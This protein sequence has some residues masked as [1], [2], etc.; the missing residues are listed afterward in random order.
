MVK[1]VNYVLL[2]VLMMILSLSSVCAADGDINDNLTST[3]DIN[4]LIT[5]SSIDL[6]EIEDVDILQHE[7]NDN[8]VIYDN[9]QV[10]ISE[11]NSNNVSFTDSI[12]DDANDEQVIC[13]VDSVYNNYTVICNSSY[14]DPQDV[15]SSIF[16]NDVSNN[17]LTYDVSD[18]TSDVVDDTVV[19][20]D[21]SNMT[22]VNDNVIVVD[23]SDVTIVDDDNNMCSIH[24][25][26]N[27]GNDVVGVGKHNSYLLSADAIDIGY[28]I[29][30]IK[31]DKCNISLLPTN[32]VGVSNTKLGICDVNAVDGNNVSNSFSA[33][34][35]YIIIKCICGNNC[36]YLNNISKLNNSAIGTNNI[37]Q[38]ADDVL[39][40][41][42][43]VD[44]TNDGN[45]NS[46]A[47]YVQSSDSS[48][49][50]INNITSSNGGICSNIINVLLHSGVAKFD[51]VKLS[52][53]D[54]ICPIPI[55]DFTGISSNDNLVVY[56]AY[57]NYTLI[58]TILDKFTSIIQNEVSSSSFMGVVKPDYIAIA[59]DTVIFDKK[60][61]LTGEVTRSIVSD[62][63]GTRHILDLSKFKEIN[64][65]FDVVK[66]KS[67][68]KFLWDYKFSSTIPDKLT[69]N[70]LDRN[71]P[72][73]GITA[74]MDMR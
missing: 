71:I 28:S 47:N 31:I 23:C 1:Y 27:Y 14:T 33:D 55:G 16:N 59:S 50:N 36:S 53:F 18:D 13:T 73:A 49:V 5:D 72:S 43:D 52:V 74:D 56:L 4:E 44:N 11:I 40:N 65:Y 19:I 9:D 38:S 3:S 30:C 63:G 57:E 26:A 61:D 39:P 25:N 66:H 32:V 60:A 7:I 67:V 20:V 22:V 15:S 41:V 34:K 51:I 48:D 8:N 12:I 10:D 69:V 37:S 58:S 68:A 35:L 46:N 2:A 42:T 45:A 24:T 29:M 21:C 17:V 54:T 64:I 62:V 70:T 6:V